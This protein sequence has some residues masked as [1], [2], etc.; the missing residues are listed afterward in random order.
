[1][2]GKEIRTAS[3]QVLKIIIQG[4]VDVCT[5]LGP[6]GRIH[7]FKAHRGKFGRVH[8]PPVRGE[9]IGD[10]FKRTRLLFEVFSGRQ[11]HNGVVDRAD[12]ICKGIFAA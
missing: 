12:R 1:M 2:A 9:K 5:R 6:F 7:L 3:V 8:L 10:R 4:R 11:A